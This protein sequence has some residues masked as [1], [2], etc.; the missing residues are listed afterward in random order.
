MRRISSRQNALVAAF[1]TAAAGDR[2]GPLLLDGTHLVA[3]ALAA[4]LDLRQAIVAADYAAVPELSALI[5]RLTAARVEIVEGSPAVMS[6]VS[7]VRSPARIVALA[8]R[9]R[10]ASPTPGVAALV[11]IACDVQDPGNLGA[12]ARVA[13]AAGAT[14]MVAA[15]SSADPYA[16]KTLRG[17]MGSFL[18]LPVTVER[19]IDTAVN[20]ARRAGLRV[21]ATV[22]RGGRSLYESSLTGAVAVLIGGEGAGL[23]ASLVE[24]ADTQITI[25]MTTPVESLNAAVTAAVILYEARRQREGH[26]LAVS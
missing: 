15:G 1:R 16:W 3:D 19:D 2:E 24:T 26:G 8:D 5:D 11:V 23:P 6:A 17:S 21:C 22:P 10:Q 25:P 7:P 12:I 18:R 4:G 13:E 9:P 14:S 20:R